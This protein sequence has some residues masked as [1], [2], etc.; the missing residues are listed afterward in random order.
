MLGMLDALGAGFD[1]ASVMELQAVQDLGVDQER[2]IFANP[3]KKPADFRWA[4]SFCCS[5]S[6]SCTCW[7]VPSCKQSAPYWIEV[8]A[9]KTC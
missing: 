6:V 1:C 3:C 8:L 9:F 7:H 4:C 5:S 2:V